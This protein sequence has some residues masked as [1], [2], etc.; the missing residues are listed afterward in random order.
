VSDHAWLVRAC[1]SMRF[2]WSHAWLSQRSRHTPLSSQNAMQTSHTD[3]EIR[4]SAVTE[5]GVLHCTQTARASPG[6]RQAE[7]ETLIMTSTLWGF[8]CSLQRR[9]NGVKNLILLMAP[10]QCRRVGA[11]FGFR[12]CAADTSGRKNKKSWVLTW[13]GSIL[14]SAASHG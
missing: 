12:Q 4:A 8:S 14:K 5:D 11:G 6:G 9:P 10:R 13:E 1:E 7:T 3:H 2:D